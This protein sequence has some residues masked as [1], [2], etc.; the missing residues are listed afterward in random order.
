MAVFLLEKN[1]MARV[2]SRLD[3]LL[4]ADTANYQREMTRATNE[5]R[6]QLRSIA[7]YGQQVSSQL[8]SAFLQIGGIAA[9][10]GLGH[11]IISAQREFD[12]LNAQLV[13]AAGSVEAAAAA[14]E[15]LQEFAKVTPYGLS[16]AVE[17]FS[18]LKNLGLEASIASL[19]SFGNTASA[20]GKDLM[21]MIEAVAD[22]STF[23][24]ERLKEFGIKANQEKDKVSF[25]FQGITTEVA[26]NAKAIEEYLLKIGNVQFGAAMEA[27]AKTL[28]GAISAMGDSWQGFLRS[29]G[30]ADIGGIS[31]L[32]AVKDA[33][34][35]VSDAMDW[36]A[37]NTNVV[38]LAIGATAL[39]FGR[40]MISTGIGVATGWVSSMAGVASST[41]AATFAAN[42]ATV[43]YN[44]WFAASVRIVGGIV[45]A[46][47]AVQS[48]T[49]A[50]LGY[51]RALLGLTSGFNTAT[52]AA[53][54]HT[55][56][57]AGA[58]AAKRAFIGVGILA[59]NT[60]TGIGSAFASLGRI[61]LAHPIITLTAVIGAVIARTEGLN[62][63]IKS[64]GDAFNVT[65][66]LAGNFINGVVD[67]LGVAWTAA[68]NYFSNL[69]GGADKATSFAKTSFG[70]FFANTEKG[71]VGVL[72]VTARVFDLAGAH[73]VTFAQHAWKNISSLG[74]SIIN[75][76]KKVGNEITKTFEIIVNN[77]INKINSVIDGIN[78]IAGM[79]G[80]AVIPK[81]AQVSFGQMQYGQTSYGFG[82][83]SANLQSNNQHYL[84]SGVLVANEQVKANQKLAQSYN[85]V[86][87]KADEAAKA[88]EK[89]AAAD[90]KGRKKAD[91]AAKAQ[92]KLTQA[93]FEQA[94]SLERRIAEAGHGNR[95]VF[96]LDKI[97]LETDN[98]S[99]GRLFAL[100]EWEKNNLKSLAADLDTFEVTNAIVDKVRDLDVQKLSLRS[101]TMLDDMELTLANYRELLG[102]IDKFER[103]NIELEDGTKVKPSDYLRKT[104]L[105]V[106]QSKADFEFWKEKEELGKELKLASQSNEISRQL[107]EFEQ[108]NKDFISKYEQ[109][110]DKELFKSDFEELK[111]LADEHEAFQRRA[112]AIK[113]SLDYINE[114]DKEIAERQAEL[115]VA[116]VKGGKLHQDL[117]AIEQERQKTLDKYQALQDAGFTKEFEN[118]K[119]KADE[120]ALA[121]QKLVVQKA[122]KALTDNL[123][124]DEEKRLETLKEQLNVI[125]AQSVIMGQSVDIERA[126]Q[127]IS[128]SV[129]LATP[130][131]P[132]EQLDAKVKNQYDTLDAGLK[133]LLENERLTEEERIKITKWGETERAKIKKAYSIATNNLILSDSE[134]MFGSLASIAKDGLGE[135]S[136]LY[137]VMFAMQQGFAIAQASIA[138]SQAMSR[139]LAE[140]FPKGL[141]DMAMAAAHGAKIISAIKSVVMPVGQAHDGIMSV[142]KSGTWNLEKG[143][144]VLPR[145]TAQNLDNT[146]NRLQGGGQV[147]N[148]SVTVNANNGDVQADEIM[149]KRMGDAIKLAVQSELQKER[150]QGGLLYGR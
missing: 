141:A 52:V 28:D 104:V 19:T 24:F 43:A 48:A 146:L 112:F 100:P 134:N 59:A 10:T 135:Q 98:A 50:T 99:F 79:F 95:H 15:E 41:L 26:K 147:I 84:E 63:A 81:V 31:Y 47:T 3:I 132:Y 139:G 69:M 71:F 86:S 27:R 38:L 39:H 92:K 116:L 76:F 73:V 108:K 105:A 58:T 78:Y 7:D 12:V 21:Q 54:L 121:N 53:R 94:Q 136:K 68:S 144:R 142:P 2:L 110:Q 133:K 127:L 140:G 82:G 51:G 107:L 57:I 61:I 123:M 117:Y 25:T 32:D 89:K 122:Y 126:K 102:N 150:R 83:Y 42:N 29:M 130:T 55:A 46:A 97:K 96:E 1:N 37:Q 45:S 93:Y 138:M 22:A 30:N 64:L 49:A 77:Q 131:N 115:D 8:R 85:D 80:G 33:V 101:R 34:I 17:G 103:I 125:N 70:G 113:E 120:L 111:R 87:K 118:I 129:G 23:E 74:T 109:L 62:G 66:I 106:E 9:V 56:A 35:K 114:T 16:Q 44:M 119:V 6:R 90:K 13:T 18:K 148:V 65:A 75:L 137:R 36:A 60:I 88:A 5:T 143:E 149:G 72:Q 11:S 124:T 14:M 67:G 4:H 91:E 40:T 145:H 20:M 128:Q